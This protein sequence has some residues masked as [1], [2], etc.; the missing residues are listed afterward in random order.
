MIGEYIYFI[1]EYLKLAE[2]KTRYILINILS[3]FFYKGFEICLPLAASGIIK[4][5]TLGNDKMT[6]FYLGVLIV[7]Y[8]LYNLSLYINY[9]I[10]GYNM[11]Y[12]YDGLTKRVLNKLSSV[13]HSFNRVMS[14]GRIINTINS[15]II[16]IG[17]MNDRISEVLIGI[18]QIIA[19]LVIVAFYNIYLSLLLIIF[20]YFYITMQNNADRKVNLYHNKVVIQDDKYSNL[21]TQIVSGLQEIKT[22][23]MLSKLKNKLNIIQRKFTKEYSAKRFYA[24]VRD[25]DVNVVVYVFRAILY[26]IL[27]YSMSK[28]ELGINV[29][30]LMVSYH[31]TLGTY[32]NELMDS[33]EAIRETNT[34]VAR[35][36]DILNYRSNDLVYG[37]LETDDIYGAIHMKNVSLTLNNK[38]ILKNIN[39]KIDHNKVVAIVGEAGSGKTMIFNLLLR[40]Y[41]PTKGR[42][43]LDNVNIYDFSREIYTRNVGVVNQKPFIFN[44]SI[45][46]NLD[47]V[48]TNIKN[49]IEACKRAGIHEFIESLPN[50]YHTKLREN[51]SNISGGQKQMISIARTILTDCEILLLDDI[52]TALDPDTAKL[53]PRL[54]KDL[55]KDHTIIL[56][57]KKPDLMKEADEIVVLDKG[58]IVA[59]GTHK[60]LMKS[61]E[62]YQ[63]L[64][65]RK[66]PS[67]IG[68][69]DHD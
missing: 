4:Y 57:T 51:G 41:Q 43:T 25:N 22:F 26:T 49:Q 31:E 68:V 13:D 11:N 47:F 32:I 50:G 35:I 20:A 54:I 18:L 61:N 66:S 24:T 33:T 3:A 58:K 30:V 59:V 67:R 56:T 69:F 45:R 64:Q 15:D 2:I 28:G 27:I 17:D 19:V 46:K 23:N 55:K 37:S 9:K 7:L 6:Y 52:T 36:N 53:V 8:F 65:S 14:K 40:L 44:M 42:I 12:C 62:I 63:V 10:Y 21:L 60:E 38:E 16:N 39:L 1:K 48:D 29:L 5:L 34:S